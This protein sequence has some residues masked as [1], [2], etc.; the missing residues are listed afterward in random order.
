MVSI[1]DHVM[2]RFSNT[3]T[4]YLFRAKHNYTALRTSPKW[5]LYIYYAICMFEKR[6]NFSARGCPASVATLCGYR[7][8]FACTVAWVFIPRLAYAGTTATTHAS[9]HVWVCGSYFWYCLAGC[10]SLSDSRNS[11]LFYLFSNLSKSHC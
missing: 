7:E 10:F 3:H 11:R 4:L 5:S 8:L 1:T 2:S 6:A 9:V